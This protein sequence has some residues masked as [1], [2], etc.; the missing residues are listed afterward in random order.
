MF[1][2]VTAKSKEVATEWRNRILWALEGKYCEDVTKEPHKRKVLV[3]ANPFGGAGAAARNWEVAR[4]ILELA[5]LDVTLQ[6][7]ERANHAH[8]I[9]KDEL[10]PG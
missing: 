4:P 7:T 5:H 1:S 3:L 10:T 8:D 6:W 9:V 2:S